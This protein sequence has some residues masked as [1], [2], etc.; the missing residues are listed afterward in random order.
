[1]IQFLK[2]QYH[3]LETSSYILWIE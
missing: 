2:C 3:C 1:M